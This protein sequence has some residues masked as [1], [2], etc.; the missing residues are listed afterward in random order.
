MLAEA[1]KK[2]PM[3]S[4]LGYK[5]ANEMICTVQHLS[6]FIR[7]LSSTKLRKNMQ[8]TNFNN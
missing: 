5:I 2:E 7:S 8:A 1:V 3:I 6:P 4:V